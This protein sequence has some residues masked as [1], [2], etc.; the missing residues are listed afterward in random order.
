MAVFFDLREN[1]DKAGTLLDAIRAYNDDQQ[2]RRVYVLDQM[3][4]RSIPKSPFAYWFSDQVYRIFADKAAYPAV[5]SHPREARSG[6]VTG[7]DFRYLRVW[8][9][10][11]SS[12][13][14]RAIRWV[15]FSKGGSFAKYYFD[16]PFVADWDDKAGTFRDFQGF[17]ARE[18]KIPPS[19]DYYFIRP[20]ITW[21]LRLQNYSPRILSEG[22]IFATVSPSLFSEP[23]Q[24]LWP[25]LAILNSKPFEA[26]LDVFQ[27]RGNYHVGNIQDAPLPI[28]PNP[29]SEELSK[30][31]R[32]IYDLKRSLH[33]A[34]ETSHHFYLPELLREHERSLHGRIMAWQK[35]VN[36]D[37]SQISHAQTRIDEIAF[38]LYR[39]SP[40]QINAWRFDSDSDEPENHTDENEDED[41]DRSFVAAAEQHYHLVAHLVSY[42]VGC[43][44]GRWDVRYAI[45]GQPMPGLPDPFAPLPPYSP[46]MLAGEDSVAIHDAP[47]GYPITISDDGVL[48]DDPSHPNDIVRR[49]REVLDILFGERAELI[50]REMCA[51]LKVKELRDYFRRTGKSSFWQDHVRYYTKSGR[52]APIYWMLQSQ[53]KRYTIWLYYPR[54]NRETLRLILSNYVNAKIREEETRLAAQQ[55]FLP[56][57]DSDQPEG[58]LVADLQE[59]RASLERLV[60]RALIPDPNDGVL[61]TI[62]PLHELV[63]WSEANRYWKELQIGKHEWSSISKQLRG[64]SWEA[65]V[66]DTVSDITTVG[67]PNQR[68]I[69][70]K[71]RT[72]GVGPSSELLLEFD[73]RINILTGDNG[74]GKTFVLDAAWLVLTLDSSSEPIRPPAILGATLR[75]EILYELITASPQR[76]LLDGNTFFYSQEGWQPAS[77]DTGIA[78]RP[79]IV[80]YAQVDGGISLWDRFKQIEL[81]RNGLP[82]ALQFK[83]EELWS[84]LRRSDQVPLCRGF[85]EDVRDWYKA[86]QDRQYRMRQ[87]DSEGQDEIARQQADLF[88]IL[89]KV[90]AVLSPS[91]EKMTIG[92]LQRISTIDTT[93]YPTVTMTYGEVPIRHA[94]AAVKRVLVLAYIL[95]WAWSEHQIAAQVSDQMPTQQIILLIDEVEQHLHP[96]WQRLIL[97]A[98][99]KAVETL[100][101]QLNVQLIITTHAP[102]VLAS[103]E[104]HFE[105]D[106]DQLFDFDLVGREV[107]LTARTWVKQ[108]RVDAWL[109]S[110][111]FGLGEGRSPEAEIAITAAGA[112]MRGDDMSHF[113]ENLRTRDS[114]HRELRH[115]VPGHDPF[116]PRWIA[117][118]Q[119]EDDEEQL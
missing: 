54:F 69:L 71:L 39:L 59:F 18:S 70:G 51:L 7:S 50:E 17:A 90:L 35:H 37:S 36:A 87:G 15:P 100:D 73:E 118:M 58:V 119:I 89:N 63:P 34:D 99:L 24:S 10:V 104:P 62:A 68:A 25:L 93:E 80:V 4:F 82:P 23:V 3:R 29:V 32:Q 48:V 6:A 33:T 92:G 86:H 105:E 44:F 110:P 11:K 113:P 40:N 5:H 46:G 84:G 38:D 42:L 16:F 45:S 107:V 49:L 53:K 109:T 78:Q 76:S 66:D 12:T 14:G 43:A 47:L 8:F 77:G 95:V 79:G 31:A 97:P 96:K 21:P 64:E 13:I 88:D 19:S 30:L 115:V 111:I 74:L 94:S 117:R 56:E 114:L 27:S 28:M 26:L 41:N 91:D 108:G 20:G 103:M 61:L 72:R 116:W 106:K 52:K 83:E 85:S 67:T 2:D 65:P 81:V 112:L 75:P 1:S 22:M 55:L 60:R 98:L 101:Q 102:L 9:E 57:L